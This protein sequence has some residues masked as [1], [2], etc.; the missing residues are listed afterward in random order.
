MCVWVPLSR[1]CV[2][3]FVRENTSTMAKG[4]PAFTSG[5]AQPHRRAGRGSGAPVVTGAS[6]AATHGSLRE[7]QVPPSKTSESPTT[8]SANSSAIGPTKS[9]DKAAPSRSRASSPASIGSN[10]AD[11]GSKVVAHDVHVGGI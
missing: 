11:R 5:P 6:G 9:I 3:F 1:A 10:G 8:S 7:E 2:L 4:D